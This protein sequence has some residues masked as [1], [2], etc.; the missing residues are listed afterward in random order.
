[1]ADL[2]HLCD[3]SQLDAVIE[4]TRVPLSVPI[5]AIGKMESPPIGQRTRIT[6]LDESGQPLSLDRNGWTHFS[7]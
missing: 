5:T 2:R 3:L 6:V 4:A 1:M 7:G